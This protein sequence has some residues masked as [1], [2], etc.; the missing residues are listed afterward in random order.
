MIPLSLS[1]NR[2]QTEAKITSELEG[3]RLENVILKDVKVRIGEPLM[4]SLKLVS[5]EAIDAKTMELIK[6][7]IEDKI[8]KPITLEVISAIEF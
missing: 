1:F 3:I 2:I 6:K 4:V 7:E 8:R 5:S